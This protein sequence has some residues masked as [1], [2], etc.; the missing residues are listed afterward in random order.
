MARRMMSASISS[1]VRRW[2]SLVNERDARR[3]AQRSVARLAALI[4]GAKSLLRA[5]EARLGRD[6]REI[7]GGQRAAVA[8]QT[9]RGTARRRAGGRCPASRSAS[10][11]PARRCRSTAGAVRSCSAKRPS[12]WRAS[13]GMS[14][15]RSR[16]GGRLRRSSPIRSAE[17][18]VEVF[19]QRRLLDVAMSAHVDGLS[20]RCSRPGGLRRSRGRGRAPPGSRAASAGPRRATSVP[21]S[22]SSIRPDLRGERAREGALHMAEQLAVDDVGRHALQSTMTSGPRARRLAAWIA[23]ATVSLPVPGSPMIRIGRRLRAALAATASA[24]R[25]SG[26]APTSCSSESAGASFSETGRQLASGAAAVGIG[27]ERFE[28]ALGRDRLARKS[29]APARIASTATATKSP[30]RKD[31]D[32]QSGAVARRAA[33]ARGPCSLV[34]I[35][36]EARPGLRGRAG[37]A[38]GRRGLGAV[39]TDRAPAGAR[40]DCGQVPA[41]GGIGFHQQPGISFLRAHRS[42]MRKSYDERSKCQLKTSGGLG[43]VRG[44]VMDGPNDR[45]YER[46]QDGARRASSGQSAD[47]GVAHHVTTMKAS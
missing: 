40:G 31:D 43:A 45:I 15:L 28:Q 34:P 13:A 29:V 6:V 7:L 16:S 25:N 42:S 30:W 35:G 26:A 5:G 19:G 4:S 12:R 41:L 9:R 1:S 2:P 20:C 46:G 39:G 44:L 33:I 17:A 21:L 8:L 10:A 18:G 11:P 14:P 23:R 47:A 37:L 24:A 36:E 22:A 3:P 32:R 27:G 38:A